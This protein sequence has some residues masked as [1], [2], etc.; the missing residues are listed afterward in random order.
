MVVTGVILGTDGRKMSKNFKNYPD[1]KEMITKY[2][3]DAL[4]L[5][6][7]GCPVMKG[8]DIRISEEEYREQVKETL[9]LLWNIYKY[10]VTYANLEGFKRKE[11]M[12]LENLTSKEVLDRW[13]IGLVKQTIGGVSKALDEYD[14]VRA[15]Q[16]LEEFLG[17]FS[18]WYIRRSRG[19]V[20]NGF[21]ETCYLALT[22]LTKLLAPLAP[23]ISE[24]IYMNLTNSESVHLTDWPVVSELDETE[25]KLIRQMRIVREIV[26]KGHAIRKEKNIAV[27]QPLS[28]LKVVNLEESLSEYEPLI[29]DELNVKKIVWEK[30]EG[31]IKVEFDLKIT[32][33][34][35]SEAKTRELIRKIQVERKE[36]GFTLKAK[37][38]VLND[39]LPED[40]KQINLI[41]ER[42]LAT[43]LEKG[44]F[45]VSEIH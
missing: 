14:S 17:D 25:S 27:R 8:E 15:I 29:L 42:T 31:E 22:T 41:K 6:L 37:I 43:S 24:E 16:N 3:G 45:K 40:S 5:Y 30:G 11:D 20:D 34:L 38:A 10:F 4:R 1:P 9:L 35:V 18:R 33:E 23:F 44:S 39:W 21:F 32:E 28:E 13:M 19:R 36:R 12:N 2:G 7:L 26:E